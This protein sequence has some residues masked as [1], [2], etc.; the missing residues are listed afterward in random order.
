MQLLFLGR[1]RGAEIVT[2]FLSRGESLLVRLS[3]CRAV[4]L[5]LRADRLHLVLVLLV[6]SS[7]GLRVLLGHSLQ[8]AVVLGLKRRES[9]RM[10]G[11]LRL[12]LRLESL[13]LVGVRGVLLGS[14]V[15]EICNL[16]LTSL[17]LGL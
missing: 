16:H 6:G 8:L 12:S 7:Q 2:V 1:V 17:H 11:T 14:H 15:L 13:H 5:V 3:S 4:G 10:V 9:G